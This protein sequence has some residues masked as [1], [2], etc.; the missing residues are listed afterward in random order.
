MDPW[1]P[2]MLDYLC[3]FDVK[4]NKGMGLSLDWGIQQTL[5]PTFSLVKKEGM[6]LRAN[7]VQENRNLNLED[8]IPASN[9]I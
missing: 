4:R 3:P 9:N 1:V 7:M 2:F 6:T 8:N 5:R